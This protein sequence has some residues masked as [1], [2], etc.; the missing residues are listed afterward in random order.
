MLQTLKSRLSEHSVAKLSSFTV[1]F[2][3]DRSHHPQCMTPLCFPR[4]SRPHSYLSESDV[5][6]FC[7][8]VLSFTCTD[9]FLLSLQCWSQHITDTPLYTHNRTNNIMTQKVKCTSEHTPHSIL[10]KRSPERFCTCPRTSSW[11][12]SCLTL[13]LYCNHHRSCQVSHNLW[14]WHSLS[15]G[16]LSRSESWKLA[17]IVLNFDF[18]RSLPSSIECNVHSGCCAWHLDLFLNPTVVSL[19]T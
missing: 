1:E 10:D 2:R 12:S 19:V 18:L 13:V 14:S 6:F 4:S 8:H 15:L 16:S 9:V 11:T 3:P 7:Q 5:N 17:V